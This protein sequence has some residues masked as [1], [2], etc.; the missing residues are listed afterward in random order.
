MSKHRIPTRKSKYYVPKETFLTV[1]HYC[2]Q[3]PLWV[4]ELSVDP[5]TVRAI[6]YDMDRVQASGGSDPTLEA[7]VRRTAIERKKAE[8][9]A[10]AKEV[11]DG[12]SDWLIEGVC[13]GKTYY[14]LK[15]KG[16]PCGKNLYYKW[17][18]RFYYRMAQII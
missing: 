10:A 1:L 8:V 2:R 15:Q 17:R 14:Q 4:A 11:A 3:Y 12:M 7:A 5:S 16:I 18:R 9:D 13:Y 6:R